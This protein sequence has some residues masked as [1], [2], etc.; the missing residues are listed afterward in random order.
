MDL[1]A[2]MPDLY[3][4]R[5]GQTEWNLQ[6]RLQGRQDSPL[7]AL[8]HTQAT[9]QAQLVATL[10]P[11]LLRYASTAGRAIQTAQIVFGSRD[12]IRDERLVEIGV[13]DFT[14]CAEDD[15]RRSHPQIFASGGLDW[16]DQTPNGED[17]AALH[18]RVAGF[19]RD[20]RGPAII[21]THGVT[22]R[23]IRLIA[24]G[25][26]M[27]QLGA[28]EVSQGALHRVSAGAHQVFY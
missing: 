6:G 22:L 18:S 12:F 8:G 9:R 14:G 27:S 2:P 26:A 21:V 19:L 5:H 10:P 3:L 24:M 4:L 25:G 23:M 7:T 11:G 13:G 28:L 16:Y 20:L 17:F 15:L 1:I